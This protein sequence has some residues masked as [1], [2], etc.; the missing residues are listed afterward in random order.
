MTS[1]WELHGFS[2]GETWLVHRRIV[3]AILVEPDVA[4][5][6]FTHEPSTNEMM[7]VTIA[8]LSYADACRRLITCLRLCADFSDAE[9]Q[10]VDGSTFKSAI[11]KAVLARTVEDP[12]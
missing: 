8:R 6:E 7:A 4:K 12:E 5:G 3:V 1:E 2:R 9:L 10:A 11:G